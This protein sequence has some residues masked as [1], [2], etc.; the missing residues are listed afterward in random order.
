[1]AADGGSLRARG[2]LAAVIGADGEMGGYSALL[3]WVDAD[4]GSRT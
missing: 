2:R 4:G 3:E 1:M